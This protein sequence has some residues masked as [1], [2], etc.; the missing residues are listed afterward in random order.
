VDPDQLP[1]GNVWLT[2][3]S[4]RVL[5]HPLR[6]RIVGA[7][8]REGPA[9]ATD[10]AHLLGTNSGATSYHLRKLESVGLV[11]DTGEGDGKRR[12]W[13]ASAT[14]TSWHPSDFEGDEDSETALHWLT[15]DYARH[16]TEQ[17]DRWLDVSMSWPAAWQDACGQDDSMVLVSAEQLTAMRE[18]L[19]QVVAPYRRVGQGNPQ[20][21]RIAVYVTAYPLDLER[22]TSR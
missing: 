14:T 21:K 6:S 20:A 15:R 5:A 4:L 12:L 10:L 3:E 19:A 2:P 9:T 16:F 17:Y 13:R 11:E 8:R 7:L 1:P 22:A 18:E